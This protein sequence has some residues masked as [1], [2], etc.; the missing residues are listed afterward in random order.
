MCVHALSLATRSESSR[1]RL[2]E[3]MGYHDNS[4]G[5]RRSVMHDIGNIK[6]LWGYICMIK[7]WVFKYIFADMER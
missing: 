2:L 5:E 4:S 7:I 1:T 3:G 6:I